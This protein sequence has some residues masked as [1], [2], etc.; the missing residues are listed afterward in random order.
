MHRGRETI[1]VVK[2]APELVKEENEQECEEGEWVGQKAQFC[3]YDC[4]KRANRSRVEALITIIADCTHSSTHSHTLSLP[5]SLPASFP[6]LHAAC[7]H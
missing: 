3:Q 1:R 2:R 6:S 7:E 5:V 4:T